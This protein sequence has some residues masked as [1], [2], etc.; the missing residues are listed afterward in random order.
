MD[1]DS[2]FCG[3]LFCNFQSIELA[4]L[5]VRTF[6]D[7]GYRSS[8]MWYPFSPQLNPPL[9][10]EKGRNRK[11]L[12][13]NISKSAMARDA[14]GQ[15]GSMIAS[16]RYGV[17]VYNFGRRMFTNFYFERCALNDR[18][19][20]DEVNKAIE[21]KAAGKMFQAVGL[22]KDGLPHGAPWYD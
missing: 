17:D 21:M 20:E 12:S 10:C 13:V 3:V 8:T 22:N 16:T 19:C 15:A 14:A 1:F 2:S 5:A 6:H 11:Y 9:Y 18:E 7:A 4:Q